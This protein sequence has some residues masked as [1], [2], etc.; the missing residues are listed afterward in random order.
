MGRGGKGRGG[1]KDL[2]DEG[3]T[4]GRTDGRAHGEEDVQS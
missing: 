1:A 3:R 4:D 2:V